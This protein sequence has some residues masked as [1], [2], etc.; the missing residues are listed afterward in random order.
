[1]TQEKTIDK[2][3]KLLEEGK[4]IY[5]YGGIKSLKP[6]ELNGMR[7]ELEGSGIMYMGKDIGTYHTFKSP[8]YRYHILFKTHNGEKHLYINEPNRCPHIGVLE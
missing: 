1:M 5:Y 2:F 4:V 3:W 8:D 7:D 6:D